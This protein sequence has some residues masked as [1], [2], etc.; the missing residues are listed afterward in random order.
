MCFS[1]GFSNPL[2]FIA[3]IASLALPFAAPEV[4]G[5]LGAADIGAEAGGLGSA[6]AAAGGLT[7]AATAGTLGLEGASGLATFAPAAADTLSS[8]GAGTLGTGIADIASGVLGATGGGGGGVGGVDASGALGDI[9]GGAPG[10]SGAAG[11]G[12][13]P[14]TILGG[15]PA[16]GPSPIAGAST[17]S[18]T[19]PFNAGSSVAAGTPETAPNAFGMPG[20]IQLDPTTGAVAEG[21]SAPGAVTAGTGG[22]TAGATGAA[23]FPQSNDFSFADLS[24]A[25]GGLGPNGVAPTASDLTGLANP[26]LFSQLSNFVKGNKDLIGLGLGGGN[27]VRGLMQPNIDVNSLNAAQLAAYQRLQQLSQMLTQNGG[28]LTPEQEQQ[29]ANDLAAVQSGIKSNYASKGMAPNSTAVQED[30]AAAQAASTAGKASAMSRNLQTGLQAA[31]LSG[32]TAGSL[33]SYQLNQDAELSN[34]IARLAA[35]GLA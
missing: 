25:F 20:G 24:G 1:G 22:G 19:D 26:G 28:Q 12:G 13:I 30:L 33:L 17:S 9:A 14:D 10:A 34:M 7:D 35:A 21:D 31:G 18:I 15:A 32:P 6:A 5:A 16:A 23:A 11:T 8:F 3:P 4:F 2:N 29:F 27:I